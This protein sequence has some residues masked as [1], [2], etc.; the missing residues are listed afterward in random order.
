MYFY[1][2]YQTIRILQKWQLKLK[3]TFSHFKDEEAEA[4]GCSNWAWQA[5]IRTDCSPFA[6]GLGNCFPSFPE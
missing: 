1:I 4:E 2:I 5:L 6:E 3:I